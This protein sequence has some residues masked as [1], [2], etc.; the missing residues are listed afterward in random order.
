MSE[1]ITITVSSDVYEHIV[2]QAE[3]SQRHISE[4]VEDVVSSAF[5]RPKPHI[6][7]QR[8]QMLKEIAAYKQMHPQLVEQYLGQYVA[9]Y[10]GKLIDHDTNSEALHLRIRASYPDKIIL[11]RKVERDADPVLHF[12]SPRIIR[13]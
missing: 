7:P 6:H 5:D 11:Q 10:Q 8:T 2:E 9:I 4:L 1:Q 3:Q 13:A 12:R